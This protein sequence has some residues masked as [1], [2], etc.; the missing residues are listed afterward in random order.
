[1][2]RID[3]ALF[4]YQNGGLLPSGSYDFE[5]LTY[6]FRDLTLRHLTE[7]PDLILF[8]EGKKFRANGERGLRECAMALAHACGTTTYIP[9][10]GTMPGGDLGPV[11]LYNPT[12]LEVI[13]WWDGREWPDKTN[14]ARFQV[15]DSV[16]KREFLAWVQHWDPRSGE[17]RL[18]QALLVDRYGS[19][20][21]LPVLGG[22][23]LNGTA[24]GPHLPGPRDWTT[25]D[26]L[27]RAHQGRERQDGTWTADT[28][29]VDHLIGKWDDRRGERLEGA[30]YYAIAEL[31]ST[32]PLIATVNGGTGMLKDWLLV[33]A[34]MRPYVVPG[35]YA[36]HVPRGP[37]PYP[38]DHRLV[39]A[40]LDLRDS[41]AS[42]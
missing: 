28:R 14:L 20:G 17:A 21:P 40:T 25:V 30:G 33:N 38:S 6:A 35:S 27:T 9:L 22:G 4:N 13:E 24:S 7:A 41:E 18:M 3:V 1:M 23:D 34:A 10:A 5:P 29:A 32:G 19:T 31:A 42:W 39:T 2:T 12:V 16:E 11:M 8:C 15:L 36:V 26:Y 37:E